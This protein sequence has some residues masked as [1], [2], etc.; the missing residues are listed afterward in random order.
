MA[1]TLRITG[2][3]GDFSYEIVNPAMEGTSS[4]RVETGTFSAARDI[5]E[6]LA[7]HPGKINLISNRAHE[8][9]Y[10]EG[11]LRVSQVARKHGIEC[12]SLMG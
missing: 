6:I 3:Q 2:K 5:E 7:D 12:P 1:Y 8:G 4:F 10:V 11:V 9:A